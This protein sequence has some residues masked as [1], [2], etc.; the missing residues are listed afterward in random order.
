[1]SDRGP[2]P[3]SRPRIVVSRCLDLEAC[4]YDGGIVAAPTIAL[5]ATHAELVDVCPEV[6]V[7]LGVPRDPI[8]IVRAGSEQRR[9]VQ[10]RTGRDLTAAM[11]GFGASFESSAGEVD[12]VVLKARS[13]SCGI[14]DVKVFASMEAEEP[15]S[16]GVGVFAEAWLRRATD[17]PVVD[18]RALDDPDSRHRFLT[19]A[20][21]LAR[22]RDA[23]RVGTSAALGRFH[24][25]HKLLLLA[26]NEP[27]LRSLGARVAN[28]SARAMGD[29]WSEYGAGF[30][31]ALL[32][33]PS[34]FGW[35]NALMHALGYFRERV[36]DRERAALAERLA[37]AMR[38]SGERGA[39]FFT[40]RSW[41]EQFEVPYLRA[42]AFFWPY[43]EVLRA[44]SSPCPAQ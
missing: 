39:T 9:L 26:W 14:G 37:D 42:Q 24:A 22:L 35:V 40:V 15:H 30:R 34:A 5:L 18:E 8:R 11:E 10:P 43:P 20:W 16:G 28:A 13:P 4:R 29:V 33:P 38:E 41:V 27:A 19:R 3:G 2:A 12:G 6:A 23:A 1:M 32:A 7:G 36:P 25:E 31:A 21:T 44:Q 17:V